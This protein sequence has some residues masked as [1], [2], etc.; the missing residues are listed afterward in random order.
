MSVLAFCLAGCAIHHDDATKTTAGLALGELSLDQSVQ[1]YEDGKVS[2]YATPYTTSATLLKLDPSDA[3]RTTVATALATP[4]VLDGN[5]YDA[6]IAISAPAPFDVVIS[7]ARATGESRSTVTLPVPPQIASAPATLAQGE[8][9]VIELVAAPPPGA[10]VRLRLLPA[11]PGALGDVA[12]TCLQLN[13][14]IVDPTHVDGTRVTLASAAL[15]ARDPSNKNP[16]PDKSCDVKI[17]VRFETTGTR[18]PAL[19]AGSISGLVERPAYVAG[20]VHVTRNDV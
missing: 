11:N 18:D 7:L 15:F 16:P 1:S 4:L 9:L 2:V 17:G 3:F 12:P 13:N 14:A 20:G 8:D 19:G 5:H 10:H 6:T